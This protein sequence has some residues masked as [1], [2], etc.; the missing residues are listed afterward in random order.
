MTGTG[1]LKSPP[2][3]GA[4][5]SRRSFSELLRVA[6]ILWSAAVFFG[7]DLDQVT[8]HDLSGPAKRGGAN[9]RSA[10][11]ATE[12][13]NTTEKRVTPG[14]N[15]GRCTSWPCCALL[16]FAVVCSKDSTIFATPWQYSGSST[17]IPGSVSYLFTCQ[18]QR[19][20]TA[21]Y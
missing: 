20:K 21:L 2:R 5:V 3:R 12:D 19:R 7:V 14:E 6:A 9:K 1:S 8:G 10:R 17:F 18:I 11:A 16:L 13:F 4:P 15:C